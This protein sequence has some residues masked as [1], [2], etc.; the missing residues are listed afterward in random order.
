MLCC[1]C[2]H[3]QKAQAL[4]ALASGKRSLFPQRSDEANAG[5]VSPKCAAAHDTL[6]DEDEPCW[7]HFLMQ[8]AGVSVAAPPASLRAAGDSSSSSACTDPAP[9]SAGGDLGE[10]ALDLLVKCFSSNEAPCGAAFPPAPST[11][12]RG[13][14]AGGS[15]IVME[16]GALTIEQSVLRREGAQ[17]LAACPSKMRQVA[18]R[19]ES[20]KQARQRLPAAGSACLQQAGV[21]WQPA[22]QPPF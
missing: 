9:Q 2:L 14:R 18:G 15:A 1:S 3:Q 19:R 13:Q 21:R 22:S 12:G 4:L 11:P 8:E 7:A 5:A 20:S 6:K 17:R 10:R 16:G